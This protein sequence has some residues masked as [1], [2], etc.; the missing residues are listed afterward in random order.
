MIAAT[1]TGTTMVSVSASSQTAPTRKAAMP[2]SSHAAIPASRSH[3]GAAKNPVSSAGSSSMYS[4]AA[5]SPS[6]F[7]ERRRRVR[8]MRLMVSLGSAR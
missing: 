3:P 2:T 1:I 6:R 8:I 4:S 7:G 5:A